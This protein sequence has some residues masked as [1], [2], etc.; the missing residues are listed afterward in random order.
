MMP[1]K[2]QILDIRHRDQGTQTLQVPKMSSK[3]VYNCEVKLETL[4]LL[5]SSGET[6]ANLE[7]DLE[8]YP[9]ADPPLKEHFNSKGENV[10]QPFPDTGRRSEAEA[11]ELR[12]KRGEVE[13]HTGRHAYTQ[14]FRA[15]I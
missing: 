2:S 12:L 13:V 8:L 14:S 3:K 10:K 11:E 6:K 9:G 7:R 5:K 15:Q 1:K 4:R